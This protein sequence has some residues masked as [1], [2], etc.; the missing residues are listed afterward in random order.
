MYTVLICNILHSSV[1]SL[2]KRCKKFLFIDSLQREYFS[3]SEFSI[4]QI[5]LQTRTC[6]E[7]HQKS[8]GFKKSVLNNFAR[9]RYGDSFMRS[10]IYSDNTCT[11]KNPQHEKLI[12]WF[13]YIPLHEYITQIDMETLLIIYTVIMKSFSFQGHLT[14]RRWIFIS[15]WGPQYFNILS[16]RLETFKPQILLFQCQ[17]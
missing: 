17:T 7:I 4:A 11:L 13:F 12:C 10:Y 3:I 9:I 1:H 6:P 14:Y 5:I 15:P 16:Q 2:W 8:H